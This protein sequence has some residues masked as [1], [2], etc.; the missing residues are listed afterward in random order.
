[1]VPYELL[2]GMVREVVREESLR[3]KSEV[4]AFQFVIGRDAGVDES[5]DAQV[6]LASPREP[7]DGGPHD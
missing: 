6:F 7:L 4:V 5:E 1:S 3:E 2:R